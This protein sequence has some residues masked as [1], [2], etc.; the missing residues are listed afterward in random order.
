MNIARIA[1]RLRG[2]LADLSGILSQGFGKVEQRFIHEVIYGVQM[3]QSVRL[4]EIARA[5][6]E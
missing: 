3:R 1:G 5:L 4:S 2:K 6:N